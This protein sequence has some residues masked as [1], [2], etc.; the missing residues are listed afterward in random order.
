M[1][2]DQWLMYH[3]SVSSSLKLMIMPYF[4]NFLQVFARD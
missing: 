4:L 3:E 2:L 1:S